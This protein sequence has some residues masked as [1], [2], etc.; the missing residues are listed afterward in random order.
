MNIKIFFLLFCLIQITAICYGQWLLESSYY[1]DSL[2]YQLKKKDIIQGEKVRF[3]FPAYK[4]WVK[5][6]TH[7]AVKATLIKKTTL[8][9]IQG[10]YLGVIIAPNTGIV[11]QTE[12]NAVLSSIYMNLS[13]YAINI[14]SIF[15]YVKLDG[16]ISWQFVQKKEILMI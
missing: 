12:H 9:N 10:E 7:S 4:Y 11:G 13:V 6:K 1:H 15:L 14:K 2:L 5:N 3:K 8:G 16:D